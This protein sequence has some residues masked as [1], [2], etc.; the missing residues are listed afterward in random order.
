MVS[1]DTELIE[2]VRGMTDY[3]ASIM[4]DSEIQ[5][6]IDIGKE[7]IAGYLAADNEDPDNFTFYQSDTYDADRALFWF[8]CIAM[9]A[10]AGEIAAVN[11]TV[12]SLRAT[13]YAGSK[14]DL[15]FDNFDKK[16]RMAEG[17]N[18]PAI[19][20]P[21]RDNRTYEQPTGE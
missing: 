5:T 8:T 13:S 11:L 2:Q 7:E 1:S 12:G 17:G 6:L 10:K 9:K 4:S 20:A 21:Q 19:S 18:T 15:Y 3:D 16:M 14:F